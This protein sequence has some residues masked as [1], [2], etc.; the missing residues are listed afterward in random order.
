MDLLERDGPLQT[1][2]DALREA[3][4]GRG[5]VVLVSGEA[6]IGKSAPGARFTRP[7]SHRARGLGGARGGLFRPRPLGP[8]H[9]I[10]EQTGA[11]L[12]ALLQDGIAR[13]VLLAGLLDELK[14]GSRPTVMVVEDA[15][16]ADE[17]TLD[18]VKFLGRRV[19][20]VPALVIVTYRDDELGPRTPL[21]IVPPHLA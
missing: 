13:P 5:A 4:A 10:A 2:G 19:E 8:L 12:R 14:R 17:A 16:W 7:R 18:L 11:G 21:R 3:E 1:L 9:D 20:R 15:H 6:G